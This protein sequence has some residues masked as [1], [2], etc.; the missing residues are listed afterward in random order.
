MRTSVLT[1]I[2]LVGFASPVLA[3]NQVPGQPADAGGN[4]QSQPGMANEHRM[5][6]GMMGGERGEGAMRS[7]GAEQMRRM[8]REMAAGAFFR[9]K[10]GN[11][12]V[13]V[14]CPPDMTMQTCV[15]AA[16][17]L[18]TALTRAT[19]GGSAVT[20]GSRLPGSSHP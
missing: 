1:A 20:D 17:D 15:G 2:L 7:M 18:I 14:H 19:T 13:D 4:S 16:T 3:Q 8:M 5:M 10:R 12:E 11:D 9:V 6:G